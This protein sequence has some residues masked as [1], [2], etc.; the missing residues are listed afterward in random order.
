MYFVTSPYLYS[1]V[2]HSTYNFPFTF[3]HCWFSI[4]FLLDFIHWGLGIR[5]VIWC[6]LDF[7]I[8]CPK[9]DHLF[10]YCFMHEYIN[11]FCKIF[12]FK[13]SLR[14]TCLLFSE[15]WDTWASCFI[16]CTHF[17]MLVSRR[18]EEYSHFLSILSYIFLEKTHLIVILIGCKLF[19]ESIL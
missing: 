17:V 9:S 19:T 12:I 6:I 1:K 7:R 11:F 16:F 8:R 13:K 3:Y 2:G 4:F 18:L 10:I 15:R 14:G 5:L